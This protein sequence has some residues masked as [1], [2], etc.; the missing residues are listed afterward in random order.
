MLSDYKLYSFKKQCINAEIKARWLNKKKEI[1]KLASATCS[2]IQEA[3]T[4]EHENEYRT[5]LF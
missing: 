4:A 2:N 3:A 5:V 1:Y